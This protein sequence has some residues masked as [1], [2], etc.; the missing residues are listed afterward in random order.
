MTANQAAMIEG[1]R[2]HAAARE[3]DSAAW[4]Y[5]ANEMPD[6]ELLSQIGTA[7]TVKGAIRR[8]A[9]HVKPFE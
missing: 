2:I 6:W 7:R 9:V 8:V 5:V 3:L 1:V 4:A